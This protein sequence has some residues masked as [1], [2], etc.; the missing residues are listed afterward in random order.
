MTAIAI[1][2]TNV[3]LAGLPLIDPAFMCASIGGKDVAVTTSDESVWRSLGFSPRA[4]CS[5]SEHA[6]KTAVAMVTRRLRLSFDCELIV[7]RISQGEVIKPLYY[8][9]TRRHILGDILSRISRRTRAVSWHEFGPMSES[10]AIQEIAAHISTT[11]ERDTVL[12]DLIEYQIAA[13]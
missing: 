5:D 4:I 6:R 2:A 11:I 12:E 1:E 9:T 7:D 10:S 13:A 3:S 8:G